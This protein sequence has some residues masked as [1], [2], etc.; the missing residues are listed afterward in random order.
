[1][2]KAV[3]GVPALGPQDTEKSS[4]FLCSR[5]NRETIY[6]SIKSLI[7]GIN[8]K[9]SALSY[10]CVP[11]TRCTWASLRLIPTRIKSLEELNMPPVLKQFAEY[12]QGLV[13]LTGPTGEGKSTTL[14]AIIDQINTNVQNILTIEDPVEFIHAPKKV[15]FL[16]GKLIKI[17]TEGILHSALLCVRIP[18]LCSLEKCVILRSI[19]A[20]TIA[21][22]VT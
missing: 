5:R 19:A 12:R 6:W 20:I 15:L 1:V 2:L 17:R 8:T 10:H 16:S 18:M 9:I 13:L 3:A 7:L 21:K 14:A 11:Y 4:S 22:Q